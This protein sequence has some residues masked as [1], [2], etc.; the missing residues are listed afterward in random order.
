VLDNLGLV[1][2]L[3]AI[4]AEFTA[5]TGVPVKVRCAEPSPR[6]PGSTELALYRILQETLRNIEKHAHA[7]HV[8]VH[9]TKEKTVILL[10]VHDDGAGFDPDRLPAKQKGLQKPRGGLGLLGMRE[11]ATSVGG[12]FKVKSTRLTGTEIE[13]RIPAK[14]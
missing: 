1:A 12:D 11:R 6:L 8:T 9:L 14:P 3:Q 10:R 2:G 5:R 7:R 4:S 13:V